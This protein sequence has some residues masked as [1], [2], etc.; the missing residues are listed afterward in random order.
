MKRLIPLLLIIS[1]LGIAIWGS[2]LFDMGPNHTGGCIA[3]AVD[4]TACPTNTAG[5][6]THHITALQTFARALAPLVPNWLVLLMSLFLVSVF[7]FIFYKTLLY[8]KPAL[9][10]Q[11]LRNLALKS[12]YSQ[13]K[14]ISWLSLFEISPAF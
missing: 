5:F 9:L 13:T 8:P 6:A 4:G 7:L 2:M 12:S 14:I 1:F 11:R 3:Y 10:L